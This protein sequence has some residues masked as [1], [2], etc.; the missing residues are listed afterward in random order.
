MHDPSC[1]SDQHSPPRL[2]ARSQKRPTSRLS[3]IKLHIMT[4][5]QAERHFAV[6]ADCTD[7]SNDTPIVRATHHDHDD[8]WLQAMTTSPLVCDLDFAVDNRSQ[9]EGAQELLLDDAFLS[10]PGHPMSPCNMHS[11]FVVDGLS[12]GRVF[13][14]VSSCHMQVLNNEIP[15]PVSKVELQW[16]DGIG[17]IQ[18]QFNVTSTKKRFEELQ[19]EMLL[20]MMNDP[21]FCGLYDSCISS[22]LIPSD[23]HSHNPDLNSVQSLKRIVENEMSD[24]HSVLLL[25]CGIA[26]ILTLAFVWTLVQICKPKKKPIQIGNDGT[27]TAASPVTISKTLESSDSSSDR[28]HSL[29]SDSTSSIDSESSAQL[30]LMALSPSSQVKWKLLQGNRQ[31]QVRSQPK[32]PVGVPCN[33]FAS[34]DRIILDTASTLPIISP[35]K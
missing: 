11:V 15:V 20:M 34:S 25:M 1:F 5:S 8:A 6:F 9:E 13:A 17:Y 2:L 10:F 33:P 31:G 21:D 35:I 28:Q 29:D 32:L 19:A 24:L 14:D 4:A 3:T 12:K 16:E 30:D 26:V 23:N 18:A 27:Y 7:A 22:T